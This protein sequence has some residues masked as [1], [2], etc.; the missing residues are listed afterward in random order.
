M[1][2]LTIGD[3]WR[4][5]YG[6]CKDHTFYSNPHKSWS[7]ID[8]YLISEHLSLKIHKM[9]IL[10]KVWSDHNPVKL[11]LEIEKREFNWRLNTNL[12]KDDKI[13]SE[14]KININN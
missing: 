5:K 9:E 10:P 11:E 3:A 12:L 6:N 8:M 13:V 2:D 14:L 4:M 7:R 1:E